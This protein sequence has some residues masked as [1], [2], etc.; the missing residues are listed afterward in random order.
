MSP[1]ETYEIPI[2]HPLVVHFPIALILLGAVV[3][4]I[5]AVA[6]KLFW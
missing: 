3:I 6:P 1:I 2:L 4:V 5:W